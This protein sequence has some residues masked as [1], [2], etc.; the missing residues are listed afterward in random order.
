[1]QQNTVPN[2]QL[3]IPSKEKLQECIER[4]IIYR[5]HEETGEWNKGIDEFDKNPLMGRDKRNAYVLASV[6][7]KRG[8]Q[9]VIIAGGVSSQI[10]SPDHKPRSNLPKIVTQ[11]EQEGNL[12]F[13]VETGLRTYVLDLVSK[14]LNSEEKDKQM[15]ART[16][17][18]NY[19]YLEDG[20]DFDF[21]LVPA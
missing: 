20:I 1:M 4:A 8:L 12:H 10:V 21:N 17:P 19:Y 7:E 2:T 5:V 11:C 9:P 14:S 6:M 18:D 3:V 15:I 16:V 13:W